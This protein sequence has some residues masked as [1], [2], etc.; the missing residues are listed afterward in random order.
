MTDLL[1]LL[2]WF[3]VS[4]LV[5]YLADRRSEIEMNRRTKRALREIGNELRWFVPV[6]FG[7][8]VFTAMIVALQ[9]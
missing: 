5:C 6:S 7:I 8:I 3:A 1:I 2:G 4:A 9:F